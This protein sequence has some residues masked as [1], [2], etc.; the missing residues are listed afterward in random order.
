MIDLCSD[1]NLM[2]FLSS[3]HNVCK[4]EAVLELPNLPT[5]DD[6]FVFFDLNIDD[7][8][9]YAIHQLE[10]ESGI[11]IRNG[12]SIVE[13]INNAAPSNHLYSEKVVETVTQIIDEL[14]TEFAMHCNEKL[15]YEWVFELKTHNTGTISLLSDGKPFTITYPYWHMDGRTT[16][17]SYRVTIALESVS[18]PFYSDLNFVASNFS[19]QEHRY[20]NSL[21]LGMK[22]EGV[23]QANPGQGALFHQHYTVHAI[24][25]HD[26]KRAIIIFTARC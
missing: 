18:T 25:F 10:Y 1:I 2:D 16:E 15:K 4:S 12:K 21:G 6:P 23:E 7:E 9:Y 14:S 26:S 19:A 5:K 24:P 20:V 8:S 13:R 3:D 22:G 11:S 17:S